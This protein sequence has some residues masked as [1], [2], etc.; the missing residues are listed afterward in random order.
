MVLVQEDLVFS[1]RQQHLNKL[2]QC[3]IV[4]DHSICR[5]MSHGE[6]ECAQYGG[7]SNIIVDLCLPFIYTKSEKRKKPNTNN[8]VHSGSP[9][10]LFAKPVTDFLPFSPITGFIVQLLWNDLSIPHA[11]QHGR[12]LIL[13]TNS[14]AHLLFNFTGATLPFFHWNS[15][16]STFSCVEYSTQSLTYFRLPTTH[17]LLNE[18]VS[19]QCSV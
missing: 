13:V 14:D 5:V 16:S 12:L 15:S 8:K 4:R 6:T 19:S 7:Q 3:I 9:F 17:Y 11:V 18:Y 10:C 2:E 1:E